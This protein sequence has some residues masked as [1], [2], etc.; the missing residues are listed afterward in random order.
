MQIGYKTHFKTLL[1]L[2][3]VPLL[4]LM[5]GVCLVLAPDVNSPFVHVLRADLHLCILNY[6]RHSIGPYLF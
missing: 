5:V 2:A 6:S 3:E 1:T 4:S